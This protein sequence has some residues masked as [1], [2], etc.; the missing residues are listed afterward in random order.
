[1]VDFESLSKKDQDLY[2]EVFNE[3]MLCNDELVR[4]FFDLDST[5]MLKEKL[6]V[7]RARNSGKPIGSIKNFYDVLENFPGNDDKKIVIWK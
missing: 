5:K 6:E 3:Y 1:M 7:L 4:M 2:F